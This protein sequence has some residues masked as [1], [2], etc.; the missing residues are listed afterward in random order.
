MSLIE[1]QEC[2]AEQYLDIDKEV[3]LTVTIGNERKP[4]ISHYKKTNIEIKFYLKQSCL[5]EQIKKKRH[6]K[7]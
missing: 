5:L 6:V 4:R 7:R 2:V 1:N 3:S